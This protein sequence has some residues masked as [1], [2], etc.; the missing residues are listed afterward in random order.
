MPRVML[1]FYEELNDFLPEHRKKTDFEVDFKGKRSIKELINEFDV[2]Q[3]DI[4]L[5]LINGKSVDF[6]TILQNGDRVSVYPVFETFNIKSVTRLRENP[7]R[8][9]KFIV[10][11]LLKDMVQPMSMLGFD[12]YFDPAC[13]PSEII[14][15]SKNEH[16]I[17]LTKNKA[18]FKSDAVTHS[19]LIRPGTTTEQIRH[20]IDYLEFP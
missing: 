7:L 9:V 18:L 19:I 20:L 8:K 4:D 10:D 5:I 11:P 16:R 1:R 12:I 6:N 17:I 2:P 13:T 3:A 14:E 15:I